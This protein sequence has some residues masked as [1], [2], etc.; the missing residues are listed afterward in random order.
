[1]FARQGV[2]LVAILC[3]KIV[4]A[5]KK[6]LATPPRP[7]PNAPQATP[8]DVLLKRHIC[9]LFADTVAFGAVSGKHMTGGKFD[10]KLLFS[11]YV[12]VIHFIEELLDRIKLEGEKSHNLAL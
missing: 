8:V 6:L 5:L 7:Q 11:S 10:P 3:L 9:R 12:K 1:M 2:S 4:F